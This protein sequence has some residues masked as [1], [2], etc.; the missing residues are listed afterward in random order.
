[1]TFK[2]DNTP[3]IINGGYNLISGP[4][5]ANPTSIALIDPKLLSD[6]IQEQCRKL[7]NVGGK[8]SL[9]AARVVDGQTFDAVK[10]LRNKLSYLNSAENKE[11][12]LENLKKNG[13]TVKMLAQ[14]R[15]PLNGLPL[16]P[17]FELHEIAQFYNSRQMNIIFNSI[18]NKDRCKTLKEFIK[19]KYN[20]STTDNAVQ[21]LLD[22]DWDIITL[23]KCGFSA[24]ELKDAI[25]NFF[26]NDQSN[27]NL[28]I[29]KADLLQEFSIYELMAILDQN[30]LFQIRQKP[31]D[32][33]SQLVDVC[34]IL[35]RMKTDKKYNITDL[36][37]QMY[38]DPYFEFKSQ[39]ALN[40]QTENEKAALKVLCQYNVNITTIREITKGDPSLV[41]DIITKNSTSLESPMA[42][43]SL[44]DVLNN[45]ATR[46]FITRFK[47][48]KIDIKLLINNNCSL[49]L[50]KTLI[51][52]GCVTSEKVVETL[53]EANHEKCTNNKGGY[54]DQEFLKQ[55]LNAGFSLAELLKSSDNNSL[56]SYWNEYCNINSYDANTVRQKSLDDF[57][58]EYNVTGRDSDY[59]FIQFFASINKPV[60]SIFTTSEQ[61]VLNEFKRNNNK[62]EV[63][64]VS[65]T[66][67]S[68]LRGS[69]I[70][71]L[72]HVIKYYD[73]KDLQEAGINA[74]LV[75]CVFYNSNNAN[76]TLYQY[77]FLS[78]NLSIYDL[79]KIGVEPKDIMQGGFP[80]ENLLKNLPKITIQDLKEAGY[81]WSDIANAS[82]DLLKNQDVYT[83]VDWLVGGRSF[84]PEDI[85]DLKFSS[86]KIFKSMEEYIQG[87][88]KIADVV[89]G[90]IEES[91]AIWNNTDQAQK[92]L[93][94][95]NDYIKQH[96]NIVKQNDMTYMALASKALLLSCNVTCNSL[97]SMGVSADH[98]LKFGFSAGEL[99]QAG[100][101]YTQIMASPSCDIRQ[102]VDE[103]NFNE[104]SNFEQD[105][106]KFLLKHYAQCDKNGQWVSP[107]GKI[108]LKENITSPNSTQVQKEI[109]MQTKI[110]S[111]LISRAKN[112]YDKICN[113]EFMVD[114]DNA[115]LDEHG[116]I[117]TDVN[118]IKNRLDDEIKSIV[119]D[120]NKNI[121]IWT[122]ITLWFKFLL[123]KIATNMNN[124]DKLNNKDNQLLRNIVDIAQNAEEMAYLLK[125]QLNNMRQL[126][127]L[128]IGGAVVQLTNQPEQNQPMYYQDADRILSGQMLRNDV[129]NLTHD[130]IC[131]ILEYV[132]RA[133]KGYRGEMKESDIC[134]FIGNI[135]IVAEYIEN[136]YLEDFKR[137]LTIEKDG[138]PEFSIK[139][140]VDNL[141]E[142]CGYIDIN[143]F[144][145]DT[146]DGQLPLLAKGICELSITEIAQRSQND[147][148]EDH[149][150]TD[151]LVGTEKESILDETDQDLGDESESDNYNE[152]DN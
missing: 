57:K 139:N 5:G 12:L 151:E 97:H 28:Q 11:F 74:T 103:I 140:L 96:Q 106:I 145:A 43:Y 13:V 95:L 76:N 109:T 118:V 26:N 114:K 86:D 20:I 41:L 93:E 64:T 144:V 2:A 29:Q 6:Q 66:K 125:R 87:L 80:I 149:N 59:K 91:R 55:L 70:K 42:F 75:K 9:G 18:K 131:D 85:S 128:N 14:L 63:D 130:N 100:Y 68:E 123:K 122:K 51:D 53:I 107:S 32:S 137:L 129:N 152:N 79:L 73:A 7:S 56:Q 112:V 40:K 126:Q 72:K 10:D 44:E 127:A 81:S 115:Y 135:D 34:F 101:T 138:K 47:E 90:K 61:E 36:A 150:T 15:V 98:A 25:Q 108:Q 102:V 24:Y 52:K 54:E 19:R 77:S 89:R 113:L 35:N 121:S 60:M 83:F 23:H 27:S 146:K 67:L 58:K 142:V 99:K 116:N 31:H 46:E 134:R 33:K 88:D 133:R 104:L 141:W 117:I 50:I 37:K 4:I 62:K 65:Q 136:N 45:Y 17:T 148:N 78:N 3:T 48:G 143:D 132:F 16:Y 92:A 124:H 39:D 21:E 147:P 82:F 22:K 69:I 110:T 71:K 30:Q 111:D 49:Q 119:S 105:E 84:C 38:G 8:S 94:D 1:M 120:I